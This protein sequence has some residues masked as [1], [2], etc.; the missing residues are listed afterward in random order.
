MNAGKALLLSTLVI[1]GLI[2]V[3]SSV[4]SFGLDYDSVGITERYAQKLVRQTRTDNKLLDSAYHSSLVHRM[5]AYSDT[6]WGLVGAIIAAI[7]MHG[8][9]TGRDDIYIENKPKKI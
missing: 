3:A 9:A 2:I 1:P 8:I 6:A 7:G 5:N 4:S